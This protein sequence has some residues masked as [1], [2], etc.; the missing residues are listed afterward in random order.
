MVSGMLGSTMFEWAVGR[1]NSDV[2][3]GWC[4]RCM[5]GM[6]ERLVD[7]R[8]G[9]IFGREV[10]CVRALC[11]FDPWAWTSSSSWSGLRARFSSR[12]TASLAMRSSVELIR[13]M[14]PA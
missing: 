13:A 5:E 1:L 4:W 12:S 7:K 10:E 8:L 11:L 14:N 9:R 3:V 2:V 6:E